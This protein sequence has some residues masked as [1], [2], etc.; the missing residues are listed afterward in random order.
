MHYD[1]AIFDF[2][3]TLAD[4]REWF[5]GSLNEVADRFGFRQ[6]TPE[7]REELRRLATRDIVRRLQVPLWKLPAIAR[8]MRQRASEDISAIR[9]FDGVPE[10]LGSLRQRGMALAVVSSNSEANVRRVLGTELAAQISFYG[11]GSSL[12]GKAAKLRQAMKL[13]GA[14]PARTI[15]IGDESRD[16]EAA[17][18]V[19]AASAAVTWGYAAPEALRR[20]LPTVVLE[21]VEEIAVLGLDA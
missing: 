4:S 17:Q 1:L 20:L 21:T 11:C 12:F 13:V 15:C 18:S 2:D 5:F 14:T 10:A 8:H 19:S 9:L 7:E 3:G 6:T 16:I